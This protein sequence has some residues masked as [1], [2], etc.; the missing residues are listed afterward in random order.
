MSRG[1]RSVTLC[2]VFFSVCKGRCGRREEKAE[3][4]GGW[5]REGHP[6][7]SAVNVRANMFWSFF[8]GM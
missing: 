5:R 4:G 8:F 7:R 2:V 1:R 3:G 6:V